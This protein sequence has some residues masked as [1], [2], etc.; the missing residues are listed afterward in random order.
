MYDALDIFE[1]ECSNDQFRFECMIECMCM[2]AEMSDGY[3]TESEGVFEKVKNKVKGIV[4]KIINALKSIITKISNFFTSKKMKAKYEALLAKAKDL[5][6]RAKAAHA[7]SDEIADAMES[8]MIYEYDLAEEKKTHIRL[9]DRI[10]AALK[11]VS[12]KV[13]DGQKVTAEDIRDIRQSAMDTWA[14]EGW[15]E[16]DEGKAA[17]KVYKLDRLVQRMSTGATYSLVCIIGAALQGG[18]YATGILGSFINGMFITA[19]ENHYTKKH[20]KDRAE[21]LDRSNVAAAAMQEAN[22]NAAAI[23]TQAA[24]L[25]SVVEN[26][27]AMSYRRGIQYLSKNLASIEAALNRVESVVS[28]AESKSDSKE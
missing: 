17:Q 4:D 14:K 3:T 12:G 23:A 19:I 22:S 28:K 7:D 18:H 9:S 21:H 10:I 20:A 2:D 6:K 15:K 25:T 5:E 1:K 8:L 13:K 24:A 11:N 27:E 16:S 26:A